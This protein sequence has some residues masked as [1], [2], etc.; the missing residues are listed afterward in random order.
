MEFSE[1]KGFLSRLRGY[2]F[3]RVGRADR[4]ILFRNCRSVHS[5]FMLFDL[6]L[7]AVDKNGVVVAVEHGLKPWRFRFY[8]KAAHLIEV[9]SALVEK[10][11]FSHVKPGGEIDV[12][13]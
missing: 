1:A 7:Y 2:M 8:R 11:G 3:T 5:C 9:P 13:V 4:A 6:S 10:L 12:D